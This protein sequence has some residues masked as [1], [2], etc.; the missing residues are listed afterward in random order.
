MGKLLCNIKGTSIKMGK[1]CMILSSL[2]LPESL[3][4]Q[5]GV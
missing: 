2:I 3:C 1:N 5:S 4:V